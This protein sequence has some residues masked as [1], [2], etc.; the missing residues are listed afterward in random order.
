MADKMMAYLKEQPSIWQHITGEKERVTADFVAKFKAF[1][2]KQIVAIG[3]G[4]SYNAACASAQAYADY[5]GV[6]L[7][8]AM[9]SRVLSTLPL[10]G[11]EN[12]LVFFISQSGESTNTI[13]LLEEI[14]AKG[15]HTVGLT[16]LEGSSVATKS[17]V[18]VPIDCGEETVGPKTK[19]YTSTALCLDML[20]LELAKARGSVDASTYAQAYASLDAAFAMA[21][22]HIAASQAWCT[23][24]TK[25]MSAAPHM[26][27]VADGNHYPVM[28]E[29]ALKILESL[30]MPVIAYEFEE[31]LHGVQCSIDENSHILFVI[32]D[33]E[34]RERMLRLHAF[35][36]A[37]GG[38]NYVIALDKTTGI[39][40][41]LLLNS[42]GG[43]I[44]AP[45]TT[46]LPAQVISA[47]VSADKGINC[48]TSKFPDFVKALGTKNW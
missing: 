37:H 41:E 46:V 47:Q 35:H 11:P 8:P 10:Y 1:P 40:G 44:A 9:P 21:T 31:Y 15:Y 3:T 20:A 32:P 36:Q 25:E 26:M 28:Q 6:P 42:A 14:K 7:I 4:S 34:N 48:D 29:G 45:F 24:H 5:L 23:L 17:E 38:T 16:Q 43:G 39:N 12:T 30:Y 2:L 19:G 13:K 27:I 22:E 18:F 33:G